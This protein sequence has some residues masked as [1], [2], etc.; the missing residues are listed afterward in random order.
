M[1]QISFNVPDNSTME[2][3]LNNLEKLSF[4]TDLKVQYLDDG[5]IPPQSEFGSVEELI[6][7][8]TDM[9]DTIQDFRKK[10]WPEK[11]F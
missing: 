9:E 8:W 5:L 1:H 3:V 7:D 6:V 2:K 11:S 10:I 4:I